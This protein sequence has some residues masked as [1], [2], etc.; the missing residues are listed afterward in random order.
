MPDLTV[1]QKLIVQTNA[2]RKLGAYP[3]GRIAEGWWIKD[4]QDFVW[5]CNERGVRRLDH[6]RKCPPGVEPKVIA[7]LLLKASASKKG[8][9]FDRKIRY[10]K[11][12]Y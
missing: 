3:D 1:P 11:Q 9:D 12:V 2:P 6:K 8:S 4:D 7:I 10:P 5:L